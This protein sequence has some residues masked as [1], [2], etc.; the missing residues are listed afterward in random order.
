MAVRTRHEPSQLFSVRVW[1]EHVGEGQV[2]WRGQIHHVISGRKRYFR[3]WSALIE[4]L[5]LLSECPEAPGEPGPFEREAAD[6]D[7]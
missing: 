2:E 6:A 1:Q 5:R 7:G 4:Q 3:G